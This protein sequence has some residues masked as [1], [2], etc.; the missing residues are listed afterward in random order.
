MRRLALMMATLAVAG[1]ATYRDVKELKMVA[2]DENLAK[3]KSQGEFESDDCVFHIL[4]YRLGGNPEISKAIAN[5]RSGKKSKVTDVIEEEKG[6]EEIRYANNVT[7]G[8]DGF[9]AVVFG[10]NCIVVKGMAFR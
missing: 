3:G 4:G 10:K 5:A 6:T 2:F 8:T 7:V 1:C 9:D